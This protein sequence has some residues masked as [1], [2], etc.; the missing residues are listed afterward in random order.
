MTIRTRVALVFLLVLTVSLSAEGF[1]GAGSLGTLSSGS[2]DAFVPAVYMDGGFGYF[3]PFRNE[4]SMF[5]EGGGKVLYYPATSD[6]GGSAYLTGDVTYRGDILFTGLKTGSYFEHGTWQTGPAWNSY[7]EVYTS[8]DFPGISVFTDPALYWN[9]EEGLSSIGVSGSVG[10]S[11]GLGDGIVSPAVTGGAASVPGGGYETTF[12]ASLE[13]TW[14]PGL[15]ASITCGVGLLRID[16]PYIET[17]IDGEDPLPVDSGTVV[18]W[19][20]E[21]ILYLGRRLDMSLVLDG[22]LSLKDYEY[23]GD[24]GLPGDR[25]E[26]RFYIEPDAVMTFFIGSGWELKLGIGGKILYSN[27][28]YLNAISGAVDLSTSFSF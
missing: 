12:G 15:P 1:L 24:T 25:R 7:L 8:L 27:S 2:G 5:T 9:I 4:W 23:I 16:S 14:Y 20:P 18:F 3:H 10:L 19:E 13:C 28:S 17:V 26:Y 6:Y 22:S 21:I 11:A